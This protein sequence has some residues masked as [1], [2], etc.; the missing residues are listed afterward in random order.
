MRINVLGP[1]TIFE[2]SGNQIDE[3]VSPRSANARRLIAILALEPGPHQRTELIDRLWSG[4]D[5]SSD[6]INERARGRLKTEVRKARD[7]LGPARDQLSVDGQM[8]MIELTFAEEILELDLHIERSARTSKDVDVDLALALQRGE[9]LQGWADAWL[10]YPRAT[11]RTNLSRLLKGKHELDEPVLS[12]AVDTFLRYGGPAWLENHEALIADVMGIESR[13]VRRVADAL[14]RLQPPSPGFPAAV[15]DRPDGSSIVLAHNKNARPAV[16]IAVD[17]LAVSRLDANEQD[18]AILMAAF[19]EDTG[20]ALGVEIF[21]DDKTVAGAEM[22]RARR[23]TRLAEEIDKSDQVVLVGAS[24]AGKTV[25]ARQTAKRLYAEGWSVLYFDVG[26]ASSSIGGL[27]VALAKTACRPAGRHLTIIDNVQGD[28]GLA[29]EVVGALAPPGQVAACRVLALTWPSAAEMTRELLPDASVIAWQGSEPVREIA[30]GLLGD[31]LATDAIVAGVE[32]L[33]RGDLSIARLALDF[34]THHAR[35]PSVRELAEAAFTSRVGKNPLTDEEL[36][37]LYEISAL[38][39]FEIDVTRAYIESRHGSAA[40][41]LLAAGAI[42]ADRA[43]YA[44]GHRTIATLT[45]AYIGAMIAAPKPIRIAIDYLSE[46]A[47]DQVMAMLKRLDLTQLQQ[48]HSADQ[49][50]SA[51]LARAW[52]SARFLSLYVSRYS[53]QDP[54][55]ADNTASAIFAA[56]TLARFDRAVWPAVAAYIRGRWDLDGGFPAPT[57]PPPAER[58]DFDEIAKRMIEEE[59]YDLLPPYAE[60]AASIDLDRMH[61]TWVLGLLLGFEAGALAR[62][63][64]RRRQLLSAAQAAIEPGGFY[65]PKR[66]PWVTARVLMGLGAMGQSI[67]TSDVAREA[68]NWLLTAAP[69]GPCQFGVWES[70]TGSWNTAEMTTAMCLT[71]LLRCGVPETHAMIVAG[72]AYLESRAAAW[73]EPTKELDAADALETR[74]LTGRHWLQGKRELSQLLDWGRDSGPWL[75]ATDNAAVAQDESSKVP[76]MAASLVRIVWEI[77][78]A[79]MPVLL[80]GVAIEL[81]GHLADT[82]TH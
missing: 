62:D 80:E 77:V 41:A 81:T 24:A 18:E 39:Q 22:I 38:G 23:P 2:R 43:H 56:E 37:A 5:L 15:E 8:D 46:A 68:T 31:N 10:D 50:G 65:Y 16:R 44:A 76:A 75:R 27:I 74:L 19:G 1:L 48:L 79:E 71:G 61:R 69:N 11:Q 49:H 67:H 78:R 26:A 45:T 6:Q 70:G 42:R 51:Y 59:Q 72:A 54:T 14:V 55:W 57:G 28:P 33:A 12:M 3:F 20:P 25:S 7:A 9:I 21:D 35:L 63:P 58:I 82:E 53:R 40:S 60:P 64:E 17:R 36:L 52:E 4:E 29:S 13:N 47:D 34:F 32:R 73:Q 30:V 66:V